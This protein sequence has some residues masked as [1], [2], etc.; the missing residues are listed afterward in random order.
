MASRMPAASLSVPY[1]MVSMR[2]LWSPAVSSEPNRSS[3]VFSVSSLIP[4][5]RQASRTKRSALPRSPPPII[6][7]ASASRPLAETGDSFWN[8]VQ[9]AES[10]RRSSHSEASMRRR[11]KVCDGQLGLASRKAR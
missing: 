4:S 6:T 10:S 3:A 8:Q 11:R 7:L 9:T 1:S 5:L 2:A